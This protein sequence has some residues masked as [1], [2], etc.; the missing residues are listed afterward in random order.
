LLLAVILVAAR[1]RRPVRVGLIA[2]ST[3][4]ILTL[5]TSTRP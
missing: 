1:I 5:E 2:G 4:M 3:G